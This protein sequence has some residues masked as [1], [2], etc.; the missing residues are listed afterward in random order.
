MQFRAL[1]AG[2]AM[3]EYVLDNSMHELI[4]YDDL[5]DQYVAYSQM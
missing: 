2:G 5:S 1:V 3:G 4:V